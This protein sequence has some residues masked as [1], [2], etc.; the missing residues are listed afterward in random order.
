MASSM[1]IWG[2]VKPA[3]SSNP[4]ITELAIMKIAFRMLLAAMIR[5][6]CEGCERIW[7]RAYIGTL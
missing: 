6:R 5:A 1:K 3:P 4:A 7:M 2:M